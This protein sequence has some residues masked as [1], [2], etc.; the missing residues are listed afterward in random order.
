MQRAAL[1]LSATLPAALVASAGAALADLPGGYGNYYGRMMGGCGF[2]DGPGFLGVGMMLLFWGIV[3]AAAVLL[4]RWLLER[5]PKRGDNALE[6]LKERLA[7]GEIDPAEYEARRK[8]L[9][10]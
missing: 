7:R 2:G 9:E 5:G 1:I 10:G 4:V 6:I 3:L 8:A